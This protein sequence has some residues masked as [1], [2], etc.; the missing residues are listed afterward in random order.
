MAGINK[1][2]V[3]SEK[4]KIVSVLLLSFVLAGC[5]TSFDSRGRYH[6]VQKEE[7]LQSIAQG[8]RLNLQEMAELN[9]VENPNKIA[10]GMKIYLPERHYKHPRFKKLPIDEV[11]NRQMKKSPS[12]SSQEKRSSKTVYTEHGRFFWPVNGYVMSGFGMRKGTHHDGIDV[13]A[14]VGTLIKAADSGVVAFSGKMRG[15][16]NIIVLQH[17]DNFFTGYAHNS[18]NGVKEGQRV[19]Q[20]E[21]IGKVG[22][23]GRTTGPHL[24]FEV[25]HGT[26]PRNPL[27]FLPT[28]R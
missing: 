5:A 9:N 28:I 7:T 21:V 27:F 3:K 12:H 15:Y 2:K 13:K 6:V 1:L 14:K 24:H 16:G 10:L 26:K 25:R 17:K 4:L 19:K 11:I 22:L 8:Y 23:T 18:R 20:G